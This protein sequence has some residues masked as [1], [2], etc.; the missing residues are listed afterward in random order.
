MAFNLA[1][2]AKL[3]SVTNFFK[4]VMGSLAA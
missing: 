4:A 1:S 3:F 2:L